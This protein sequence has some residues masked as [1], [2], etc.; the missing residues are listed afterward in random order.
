MI[1]GF[2]IK[3]GSKIMS[4]CFFQFLKYSL[5]VD[6]IEKDV[7]VDAAGVISD[8]GFG[9]FA[10]RI[11]KKFGSKPSLAQKYADVCSS[12]FNELMSNIK[13]S[14]Y[15][16]EWYNAVESGNL[17]ASGEDL[18]ASLTAWFAHH[19]SSDPH[20]EKT[21]DSFVADFNEKLESEI[22][23]DPDL[24]QYIEA[25]KHSKT[26]AEISERINQL[27][28]KDDK[29]I[30][31]T[32]EILSDVKEIKENKLNDI[33]T[34]IEKKKYPI[35]PNMLPRKVI[36]YEYFQDPFL[37]NHK[38][39]ALSL[40]EYSAKEHRIILLGDAASGKTIALK[41]FAAQAYNSKYYPCMISLSNYTGESIEEM[42]HRECGYDPKN[43]YILIFDAFEEAKD[44]DRDSFARKLNVYS[45]TKENDIIIVSVRHN[46]YYYTKDSGS[47]ETFTGF[48]EFGLFPIN[49]EEI[50]KYLIQNDIAPESFFTQ[51]HENGLTSLSN[52]PFYLSGMVKIFKRNSSLPPKKELMVEM[53]RISFDFDKK[54]YKN[55]HT[56]KDYENEL[57]ALLK[58]TAIAM[59]LME[60]KIYI[61]NNDYDY[62]LSKH[63]RDL[64]KH[65]SLFTKSCDETWSFQHNNFREFLAA[66]YL[67]ELPADEMKNVICSD[68]YHTRVRSSWLNVLSY[69]ALINEENE[70]LEWLEEVSPELVIKFEKSRVDE[71]RRAAIFKEIFSYYSGRN[72]YIYQGINH[73][74]ELVD[75]G[76]CEETLCYLITVLKTSDSKWSLNNAVIALSHFNCLFSK[77]DEIRKSLS[78][79]IDSDTDE[80]V[81]ISAVEA[82]ATLNLNTEETM[83]SV[84]KLLDRRNTVYTAEA[85]ANYISLCDIQDEKVEQ[86]LEMKD[87][88]FKNSD[89]YFNLNSRINQA[90]AKIKDDSSVRRV[91]LVLADLRNTYHNNELFGI[92]IIKAVALYNNGITDYYGFLFKL[93]I[94]VIKSPQKAYVSKLDDFFR[95]TNSSDKLIG[96]LI[97]HCINNSG[98]EYLIRLYMDISDNRKA[99]S[100][101]LMRRYINDPGR[102]HCFTDCFGN[103]GDSEL[104]KECCKVMKERG[105][106]PKKN[107]SESIRQQALQEYANSL[108]SKELFTENI[109]RML[110]DLGSEDITCGTIFDVCF[111]KYPFGTYESELYHRYVRIVEIQE[112]DIKV[113]D[114]VSGIKDW[115]LFS[116][117]H[118]VDLLKN[119][120]KVEFNDEQIA[121]IRKYCDSFD[122]DDLVEN[123][124]WQTSQTGL[125]YKYT[126]LYFC[127]LIQYFGFDYKKE[128]VCKL[129]TVPSFFFDPDSYNNTTFSEYVLSRLTKEEMDRCVK[130]NLAERT[131]CTHSLVE[132]IIYCKEN[133]LDY[134][135]SKAE[136]LCSITEMY[137][138]Y[139]INALEYII[140][141]KNDAANNYKYIYDRFLETTDENLIQ[142]LIY[143]TAGKAEPRFRQRIE[144][145]N[146]QD[147][148]SRKYLLPLIR[149]QSGYALELYYQYISTHMSIPEL[150]E[151]N[152]GITEEIRNIKNADL[153]PTLM[154]IKK[155]L[156]EYEFKDKNTFGLQSSLYHA[157]MNI[158]DKHPDKVEECIQACLTEPDINDRDKAFCN[159]LL[160]DIKNMLERKEDAPWK[161]RDIKR[162]LKQND[163]LI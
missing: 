82:I 162:W 156:F 114:Y 55:P 120:E 50:Y 128:D 137:S 64:M 112:S 88:S 4:K 126:T 47:G 119:K 93:L 3:T 140:K 90:L 161:L 147:E 78:G 127:F 139:M 102:Y 51:L 38:H 54:K 20:P 74:E 44:N 99:A 57:R 45:A 98:S 123:G 125:S 109:N 53:I 135:L 8:E 68:S 101:E 60:N 122:I 2:V 46:F 86:L 89:E 118:I 25:I 159:S 15:L 13:Y 163:D 84:N 65:S 141:I 49:H 158:A 34:V 39:D 133:D 37:Y 145:L 83:A 77:E 6:C 153:L 103:N 111:E 31:I 110:K 81:Q 10:E 73:V 144:E 16:K 152:T 23:K 1:T 22:Q 70:L 155:K 67:N 94:K 113:T 24:Y 56:V 115:S 151:N 42:I 9:A 35:M 61:T 129:T 108:F 121:E 75:F 59:Q 72:M 97:D 150:I 143:L 92:L 63:D 117:G 130:Y 116:I 69:L 149:M 131:L 138:H 33:E 62:L 40:F 18:R 52:N 71:T 80:N 146:Q 107:D 87:C 26:L 30:S 43:N 58:Q 91:L 106:A 19:K 66:E 79:I 95:S 28:S 85:V 36:P 14:E 148:S 29:L 96:D 5:P 105:E 104:Y 7:I 27:L 32:T 136:E 48:K 17:D 134:A 124:F 154:L 41:E 11:L 21:I 142:A 132:H 76:E 12:V 100:D 157:L 160:E